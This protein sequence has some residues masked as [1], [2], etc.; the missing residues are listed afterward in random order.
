MRRICPQFTRVRCTRITN[1]TLRRSVSVLGSTETQN[2]TNTGRANLENTGSNTRAKK[3]PRALIHPSIQKS[4]QPRT[5]SPHSDP[6]LWKR[7]TQVFSEDRRRNCERLK[8]KKS[9]KRGGGED[10]SG[11]CVEREKTRILIEGG[12]TFRRRNGRED[13]EMSW[14]RAILAWMISIGSRRR[15]RGIRSLIMRI[16]ESRCSWPRQS[17]STIN[18]RHL[19]SQ[20]PTRFRKLAKTGR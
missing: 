17:T 13:A 5:R 4:H 12:R 16:S 11:R 14:S 2:R 15:R 18:S 8:K 1:R 9:E 7:T 6:N 20:T 19:T 10:W 3:C